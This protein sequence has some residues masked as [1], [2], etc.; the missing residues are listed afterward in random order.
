MVVRFWLKPWL[1]PNLERTILNLIAKLLKRV[2]QR[3]RDPSED[4]IRLADSRDRSSMAELVRILQA[5]DGQ[6]SDRTSA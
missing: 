5:L 3:D 4:T 1:S 2:W 6:T